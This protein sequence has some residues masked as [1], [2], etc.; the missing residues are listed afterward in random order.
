[1]EY[2]PTTHC[3]DL[4]NELII[5]RL[6]PAATPE[7]ISSD[8]YIEIFSSRNV[9]DTAYSIVA[10]S[11]DY[12]YHYRYWDYDALEDNRRIETRVSK[13][14]DESNV[15]T[16]GG[17]LPQDSWSFNSWSYTFSVTHPGFPVSFSATYDPSDESSIPSVD[18]SGNYKKVSR[19]VFEVERRGLDALMRDEVVTYTVYGGNSAYL[20]SRDHVVENSSVTNI[21]GDTSVVYNSSWNM[22]H[23]ESRTA[24]A[25]CCP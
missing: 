5:D 4:D 2:D 13:L 19:D 10:A 7:D 18:A 8:G 20:P 11:G 25:D 16:C 14:E 15:S 1:M 12:P 23:Y 6:E 21:S 17:N 22:S 3:C 9:A 24:E